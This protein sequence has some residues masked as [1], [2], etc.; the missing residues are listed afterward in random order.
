MKN[1][2]TLLFPDNN[3]EIINDVI[4]P[5]NHNQTIDF[6]S[7]ANS[8]QF[9]GFTDID[10]QELIYKLASYGINFENCKS[11]VDLGCGVGD[12]YHYIKSVHKYAGKYTGIDVNALTL[13]VGNYKYSAENIDFRNLNYFQDNFQDNIS[14]E[15]VFCI[16]NL[17]IPYGYHTGTDLEQ[18]NDLI[19][20]AYNICTVGCV[21]TFYNNSEIY[22]DYI[23]YNISNV[24]EILNKNNITKYAVDNTTDTLITKLIILK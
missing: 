22:N 15:Y 5:I 12:F 10:E 17:T 20:I 16:N 8:P 11:I 23:Q 3:N 7:F 13:Q 2:N 4:E 14:A 19:S 1:F 6:N 9:I 24:I 18:L 21:F